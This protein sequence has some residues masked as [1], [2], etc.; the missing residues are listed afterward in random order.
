MAQEEVI[1]CDRVP[2]EEVVE[3]VEGIECV[4]QLDPPSDKDTLGNTKDQSTS[5]Q[6][7]RII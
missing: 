4:L 1:D 3:C 2:E 7:V 6:K 5:K